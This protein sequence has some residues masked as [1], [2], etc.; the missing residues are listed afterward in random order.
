MNDTN[1]APELALL[2]AAWRAV[3]ALRLA[4]E[5]AYAKDLPAVA[6]HLNAEADAL[7]GAI[8]CAKRPEC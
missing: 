2:A 3:T 8:R 7:V 5:F 1:S 4:S 6:S